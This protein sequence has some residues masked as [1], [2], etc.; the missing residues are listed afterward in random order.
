MTLLAA[1]NNKLTES[2]D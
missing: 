1:T 2:S